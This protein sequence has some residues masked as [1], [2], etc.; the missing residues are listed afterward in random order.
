MGI[1]SLLCVLFC[2]PFGADS[3]LCLYT[4]GYILSA[5][6]A[7]CGAIPLG[8]QPMVCIQTVARLKPC[9]T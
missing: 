4:P 2:H 7:C 1:S 9:P 6:Q 5:L 8:L 3:L